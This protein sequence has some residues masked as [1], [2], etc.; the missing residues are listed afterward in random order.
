MA[1][2]YEMRK[3]FITASEDTAL[4]ELLTM[5][6][7]QSTNVDDV[8]SSGGVWR[9]KKR[10][11]D[12]DFIIKAKETIKIHT[13]S[14]QGRQYILKPE[15]VIFENEDFMVVY[16]PCDL[17]VHGVPSS[18][19]YNLNY[20][21]NNY[22]KKNGIHFESTPLTR[23][24]RPVEGLVIFSKNKHY[25][26]RLFD[27]IKRRVIKKWY[28]GGIEKRPENP[29]CLRIIDTITNDGNK[30]SADPQGKIADTLFIKTGEK[31]SADIYSI[32]IFTGRRHQIRFHASNYIAPL[33]GDWFYGASLHL[34]G[35]EISLICR[36]YNIP[37]KKK[38]LR[39]RLPQKYMDAFL[40]KFDTTVRGKHSGSIK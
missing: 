20:G 22:L 36:G 1:S 9:D 35:D 38:M 33:V 27:L 34:P 2:L 32:F 14:F 7:P 4:K 5:H 39:I 13:S 29:K 16:K 30:T 15:H 19:H 3:F 28:V 17:N 11:F 31:T 40:A 18:L 6:L 12:P 21:V 26:R 8:I 37:Y 24:D 23:I 25:E 10:V